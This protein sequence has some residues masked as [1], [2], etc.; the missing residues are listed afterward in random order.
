MK[1]TVITLILL[2]FSLIYA[3]NNTCDCVVKLLDYQLKVKANLK[4]KI[5]EGYY[6]LKPKGDN[7]YSY[8]II[9]K[10]SSSFWVFKP[11]NNDTSKK[12][13]VKVNKLAGVIC[14]NIPF[15]HI[16]SIP[17]YTEPNKDS[18]I[19]KYIYKDSRTLTYTDKMIGYELNDQ[20]F[21]ACKKDWVKITTASGKN[22]KNKYS[23]TGW[24]NK[25]HYLTNVNKKK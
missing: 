25:Q 20:W 15:N 18:P 3:Q 14:I 13:I 17:I 9:V 12:E 16:D 4:N 21:S 1:K 10:D 22:D 24:V 19:I 23:A 8:H 2:N 7:K 5:P 6:K 11:Y